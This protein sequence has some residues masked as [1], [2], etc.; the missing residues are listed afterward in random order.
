MASK[1]FRQMMHDIEKLQEQCSFTDSS[2]YQLDALKVTVEA[3]YAAGCLRVNPVTAKVV[4]QLAG[5]LH[6]ANNDLLQVAEDLH[7]EGHRPKPKAMPGSV[8]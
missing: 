2:H 6:E 8:H 4:N 5:I 3:L 7:A 1:Q